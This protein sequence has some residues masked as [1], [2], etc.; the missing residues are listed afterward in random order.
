MFETLLGSTTLDDGEKVEHATIFD[1]FDFM[2]NEFTA[3]PT[4][5]Q[6]TWFKHIDVHACL[7]RDE[8]LSSSYDLTKS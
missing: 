6:L 4:P 3:P 1:L 8:D 5:P 2:E 7:D